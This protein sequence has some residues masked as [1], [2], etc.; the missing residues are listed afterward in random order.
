M[1]KKWMLRNI[2]W[3]TPL[4]RFEEVQEWVLWIHQ[5]PTSLYKTGIDG[6]VSQW[7]ECTNTCDNYF[8]IKQI[9]LPLC[10]G[11]S[12]FIICHLYMD[13]SVLKGHMLGQQEY[14]ELSF[15]VSL[16]LYVAKTPVIDYKWFINA[17]LTCISRFTYWEVFSSGFERITDD[18]EQLSRPQVIV[19]SREGL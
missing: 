6:L 1:F 18:V 8:W 19:L 16:I 7:D 2:A 12:V 14:T 9:P 15:A 11:C 10:N 3:E 13:G 5:R 4:I 17:G